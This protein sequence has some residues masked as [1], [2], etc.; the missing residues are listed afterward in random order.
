[1]VLLAKGMPASHGQKYTLGLLV[2]LLLAAMFINRAY[3]QGKNRMCDCDSECI[4][5]SIV[6]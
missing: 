5:H 4:G 1:M 2:H 6:G 3:T